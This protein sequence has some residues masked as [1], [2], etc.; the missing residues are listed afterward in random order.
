MATHGDCP[1]RARSHR[2]WAPLA[3]RILWDLSGSF[4]KHSFALRFKPRVS[5]V[6]AG[7]EAGRHQDKAPKAEGL[8]KFVTAFNKC[9]ALS[10]GRACGQG[11]QDILKHLNFLNSDYPLH[12]VDY[13]RGHGGDFVAFRQ[14]PG[15]GQLLGIAPR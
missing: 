15:L 7:A 13:E 8:G 1:F 12:A 3:N 14:P 2:M 9:H 4:H 10:C 5:L 6:E 11:F